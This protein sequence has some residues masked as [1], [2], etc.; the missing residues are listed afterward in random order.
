MYLFFIVPH[1]TA[2][3]R[4][5]EED[6]H[7]EQEHYMTEI[8]VLPDS[9]WAGKALSA[10]EIGQ[11]LSLKTMRVLRN[12]HQYLS[13]NPDLKLEEGDVLLVQG[14]SDEVLKIKTTNGVKIRADEKYA[15]NGAEETAEDQSL[16]EAIIMIYS[17]LNGR[18]LDFSISQK[19]DYHLSF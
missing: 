19:L 2:N 17:R 10:T 12:E 3:R 4:A 5:V 13:P 11:D 6:Q 18:T 16:V 14:P 15:E 7:N 9:P 1:L 8:L